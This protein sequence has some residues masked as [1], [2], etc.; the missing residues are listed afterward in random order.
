M[1]MLQADG[2]LANDVA[3]DADRNLADSRRNSIQLIAV[4]IFH[5]HEIDFADATCVQRAH[6]IAIVE[7]RRCADLAAKSAHERL[8][9]SELPRHNL[10]SDDSSGFDV[11]RFEHMSHA[12]L[13]DRCQQTI[14]SQN[15]TSLAFEQLIGLPLR[16]QSLRDQFRGK[17]FHGFSV[18]LSG[19]ILVQVFR[20]VLRSVPLR[21]WQ[22]PAVFEQR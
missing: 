2:C 10:D 8:I 4:H 13:A 6:D 19:T 9:S 22:Q 16:Q 20:S 12:A 18:R 21:S 1:G 11:P 14:F 7:Q 5:H 3:G 15:E 17:T